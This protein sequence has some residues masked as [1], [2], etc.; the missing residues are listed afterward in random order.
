MCGSS[1]SAVSTGR[2]LLPACQVRQLMPRRLPLCCCRCGGGPLCPLAALGSGPY[3]ADA[4]RTAADPQV[5]GSAGARKGQGF[6]EIRGSVAPSAWRLAR[7]WIAGHLGGAQ[8]RARAVERRLCWRGGG[9]RPHC[10]LFPCPMPRFL[11]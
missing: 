10:M 5:T 1:R 11:E 2:R 4:R 6:A 9:A 8:T 7:V 3:L